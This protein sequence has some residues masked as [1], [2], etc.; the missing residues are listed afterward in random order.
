[1]EK[2]ETHH[3]VKCEIHIKA[4]NTREAARKALDAIKKNGLM[5]ASTKLKTGYIV[6]WAIDMFGDESMEAATARA[7]K[8]IK[9]PR[10]VSLCHVF[11]LQDKK[12]KKCFSVDLDEIYH[13]QLLPLTEEEFNA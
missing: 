5:N 4:K 2:Q 3:M 10:G 13:N 11:Q 7:F 12:T 1:M 9:E 8:W 6:R